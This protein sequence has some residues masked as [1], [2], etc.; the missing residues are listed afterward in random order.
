MNQ[1]RNGYRYDSLLQERRLAIKKW[2]SY[3]RRMDYAVLKQ[4]TAEFIRLDN[5]CRQ[6]E[7]EYDLF[8][9]VCNL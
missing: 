8:E 2:Q 6:L 5:K 4:N 7:L 1:S 9:L 3:Q